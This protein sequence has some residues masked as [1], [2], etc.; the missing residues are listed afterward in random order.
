MIKA[1]TKPNPQGDLD[2]VDAELVFL[3]EKVFELEQRVERH[4]LR[5]IALL[6][7]VEKLLDC[8][9]KSR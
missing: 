8:L 6:R 3:H 4:E 9:D 7:A 2:T 5:E 1:I